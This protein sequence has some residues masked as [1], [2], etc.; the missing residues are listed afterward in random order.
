[1][2]FRGLVLSA[3]TLLTLLVALPA[4][5]EPPAPPPPTLTGERLEEQNGVAQATYCSPEGGQFT[6]T[7]S[8][9]AEGPYP[10]TYTETGT[11]T[12][13]GWDLVSFTATFTIESSVGTVT[14]TKTLTGDTDYG[15]FAGPF[16]FRTD[17]LT[18]YQATIE[19]A[20]GVY[21]DQ[22]TS[23]MR[24]TLTRGIVNYFLETYESDQ[25]LPTSREQCKD[26]VW[27]T[28]GFR[29]QGECI[30]YVEANEQ[31]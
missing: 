29:N 8:G 12:I 13:V 31:G 22:G 26:G 24:L 19:T 10:G 5:A 9:E 30:K 1:M 14:G 25:T 6:Y 2:K 7:T 23:L 16:D 3:A 27:E 11:G 17:G 4:D 20:D 28:Y 18:T 15:C 21:T